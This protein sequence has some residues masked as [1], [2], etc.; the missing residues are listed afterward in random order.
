MIKHN[1]FWLK[2]HQETKILILGLRGFHMDNFKTE[3]TSR[4]KTSSTGQ[5]SSFINFEDPEGTQYAQNCL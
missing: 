5:P 2:M 3:Y 1:E 4:S